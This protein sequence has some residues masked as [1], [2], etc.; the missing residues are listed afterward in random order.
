MRPR[1]LLIMVLLSC[2]ES[3][4][5]PSTPPSTAGNNGNQTD[6]SIPTVLVASTVGV[7]TLSVR[8]DSTP[9]IACSGTLTA[10]AT[11][12]GIF[13]WA[14][15]QLR[16]YAGANRS[17]PVDS[18]TLSGGDLARAWGKATITE[19]DTLRSVFTF[20]ASLPF[21]VSLEFA[22]SPDPASH[23]QTRL[24]CGPKPDADTTGPAITAL[25][26]TPGGTQLQPGDTALVKYSLHAN[27]GVW[28]AGAGSE[29]ACTL[30]RL[31]ARL[32][33]P[34]VND[35]LVFVVPASCRVGDSL[36]IEVVAYDALLRSVLGGP[37]FE[38]VD[39]TPPR[40][41]WTAPASRYFNDDS[42][43]VQ[44]TASDNHALAKLRWQVLPSG[45]LDSIGLTST[46]DTV[47]LKVALPAA[48]GE[49]LT[50]RVEVVDSVGLDTVLT[51]PFA[52]V[53]VVTRSTIAVDLPGFPLD[54]QV[55]PNQGVAYTNYAGTNQCYLSAMSLQDGAFSSTIPVMCSQTISLLP[56]G[57]SLLIPSGKL[58]VIG[59][60][61]TPAVVSE[62]PLAPIDGIVYLGNTV[63]LANGKALLANT[64]NDN[65]LM[66]FDLAAGTSVFRSDA[67]LTGLVGSGALG[68][69]VDGEVAAIN[70]GNGLQ[71]YRANT[72]AF[73]APVLIIG[74][75][76]FLPTLDSTGS[77][78]SIGRWLYD[79]TG[80]Y[81]TKMQTAGG[82][83]TLATSTV[84]APSG[85][86]VY[87]AFGH[88][89][90]QNN[91]SDG[92]IVNAM[93]LPFSSGGVRISGDGS[94]LVVIAGSDA[95]IIDLTSSVPYTPTSRFRSA[96]AVR[97]HTAA[98]VAAASLSLP[99]ARGRFSFTPAAG[100]D[101]DR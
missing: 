58:Q 46:A 68:R 15:A 2:G 62:I 33:K 34:T 98:A 17:A 64:S 75:T 59:L 93:R 36:L 77:R 27:K 74:S 63:A 20:S 60:K 22:G 72:D 29:G 9:S 78:V 96:V 11:G 42:V 14:N 23:P 8:S 99:P 18:A 65:R 26:V 43:S 91:A 67:G 25:T 44:I 87:Q 38:V 50:L 12:L 81:L 90:I 83:D 4:T 100:Q 49:T 71:F 85:K 1:Y 73:T 97:H 61:P 10:T 54:L 89:L 79:G 45:P 35:S 48:P 3:P 13:T 84:L 31:S 21:E 7:P 56:S 19:R 76:A 32:L 86:L 70:M 51:A 55:A 24:A 95:L 92:S 37:K 66:A 94:K 53:P 47:D 41:N 52:V 6:N 40:A 88:R 39:H 69:S 57:D 5:T 30:G 82:P 16:W 80:A 28:L 101:Q